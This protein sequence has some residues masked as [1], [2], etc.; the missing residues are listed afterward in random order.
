MDLLSKIVETRLDSLE[1]LEFVRDPACGAVA[2]FEGT[3][4]NH[5]KGLTVKSL[6][7]EVYD[8]LY[9]KI[10]QQLFKEAKQR[11]DVKKMAVIQ[12]IGDLNVG[13]VGIVIALS[14]PHRRDALQAVEYCIEEFKKRAPVWK[15]ETTLQGDEWINWPL[16]HQST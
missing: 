7:Y 4:R 8:A 3:I 14:S 15:K 10:N 6:Y 2:S 1:A 9:H 16:E 11:W 13:D 5:N 12:R